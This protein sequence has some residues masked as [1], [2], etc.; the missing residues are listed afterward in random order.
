M[1]CNDFC[2][3][4]AL[5]QRSS[6]CKHCSDGVASHGGRASSSILQLVGSFMTFGTM[7]SNAAVVMPSI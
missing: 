5:R 4:F 1:A 3:E 6:C 7:P 2:H